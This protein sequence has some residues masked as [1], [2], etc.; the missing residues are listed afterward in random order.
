MAWY[1]WLG[2]FLALLA[3][4]AQADITGRPHVIDGDT[5]E[6]VGERVRLHVIERA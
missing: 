5:L 3:L 1:K 2:L 4:Q 6:I